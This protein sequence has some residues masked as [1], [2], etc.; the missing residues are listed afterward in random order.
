MLCLILAQSEP[1]R[2]NPLLHDGELALQEIDLRRGLA[3]AK[4]AI[5]VHVGVDDRGQQLCGGPRVLAGER[6]PEDTTLRSLF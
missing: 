5:E 3:G 2:V 4:V 1:G 6:K